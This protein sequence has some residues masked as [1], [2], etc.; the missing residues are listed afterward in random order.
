VQSEA[1]ISDW[2]APNPVRGQLSPDIKQ[3]KAEIRNRSRDRCRA[4]IHGHQSGERGGGVNWEVGI[5][6]HT[7]L[8]KKQINSQKETTT[9]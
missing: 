1:P 5:D 3:S 8:C 6:I 4:Q 9:A 2:S 7:L